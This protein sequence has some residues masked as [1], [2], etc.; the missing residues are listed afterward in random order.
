[1]VSDVTNR[2]SPMYSDKNVETLLSLGKN[3]HVNVSTQTYPFK[4]STSSTKYIHHMDVH[5]EKSAVQQISI[6]FKYLNGPDF[7]MTSTECQTDDI[8]LPIIEVK[9]T[10]GAFAQT[11]KSIL[12]KIMDPYVCKVWQLRCRQLSTPKLFW[13]G[14]NGRKI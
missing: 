13:G 2:C 12:G 3:N 14:D 9:E 11:E 5:L 1:M 7:P 10:K 4:N 8:T 6:N